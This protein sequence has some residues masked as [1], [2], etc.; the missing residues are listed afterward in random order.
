M[1]LGVVQQVGQDPQQCG[2][3]RLHPG[4]KSLSRRHQDVVVRYPLLLKPRRLLTL[5]SVGLAF[6]QGIK[7]VTRI[8]L[9]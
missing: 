9:S 4:S 5:P 8:A 6:E 3:R 2:G 1:D 7:K